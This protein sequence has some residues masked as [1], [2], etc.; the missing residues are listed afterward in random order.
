MDKRFKLKLKFPRVIPMIHFCRPKHNPNNS[1]VVPAIYR[2]S[3]M[4]P[5]VE[6]IDYPSI[7]LPGPPPSTPENTSVKRHVSSGT[8]AVGC[9]CSGSRSWTRDLLYSSIESPEYE[10]NAT[11]HLMTEKYY[12]DKKNK[13]SNEKRRKKPKAKA[14]LPSSES[15]KRW[16]S[17]EEENEESETPIYSSRS[18]S[19][20]FSAVLETISEVSDKQSSKTKKSNYKVRRLN[21]GVSKNW[22]EAE[23]SSTGEIG[24]IKS[25]FQPMR[26]CR[27]QGMVKESLAVVKKSE[28]PFEDFKK[29]MMEMIMEK[30]I[31][32]ARELEELLHCFLTLNSRHYQGVIVEAFSEIWKLVFSDTPSTSSEFYCFAEKS[33]TDQLSK[34]KI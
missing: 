5:K 20:D 26:V 8:T 7:I 13:S 19:T 3:P 27:R 1:V 23:K 32:E 28:D 31:F 2:L 14:S 30:Q 33:Q 10:V 34:L 25:V 21:R 22:K 29:S 24:K 17:S 15:S 4:N 6:D 18:F 12:N 9:G 11:P 16:F